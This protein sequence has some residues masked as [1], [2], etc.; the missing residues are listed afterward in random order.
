[1]ARGGLRPG[2]GR[3]SKADEERLRDL[4]LSAVGKVFGD[5][6]SLF[7]KLAEIANEKETSNRDK[8]S[9][10]TKLI[11][12]AHGKPKETVDVQGEGLTVKLGKDVRN[13]AGLSAQKTN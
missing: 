9:A 2:S 6:V 11:E 4:C 1:M 12:Y 10:L 5:N 13:L 8:I 3:K 7:Q